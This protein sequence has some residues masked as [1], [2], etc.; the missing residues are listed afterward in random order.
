MNMKGGVGKTTMCIHTAAAF[1]WQP[2]RVLIIDY[3]PQFNASQHLLR[4]VRYYKLENENKTILSVLSPP[5]AEITPF[6]LVMPARDEPL[7]RLENLA[8]NRVKFRNGGCLDIVPGTLNLMYLALGQSRE[9]LDPMEKR[10]ERFAAICAEAYDYVFID[11]HPA[12]SFLTKTALLA[13]DHVVIP[14]NPDAFS[15][16][17]IVLM[18]EFLD[19]LSRFG[20]NPGISIAFN[21]I[22]RVNYND[23]FENE[24]RRDATFGDKC[25]SQ[26][27]HEWA[28]IRTAPS[29]Q[30]LVY[31]SRR[32]WRSRAIREYVLLAN[33]LL[34]R[35]SPPTAGME[36]KQ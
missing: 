27:I 1:A 18:R 26:V 20:K 17:G 24:I 16:R 8:T 28:A 5:K 13:S 33:E 29:E 11:C 10:F 4:P 3:D 23:R 21:R 34:E 9:S 25:L 35:I 15:R 36:R 2:N 19:Y 6:V 7:P 22:P 32:P 30:S 14:V 31:W 12:G